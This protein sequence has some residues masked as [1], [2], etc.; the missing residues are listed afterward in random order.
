[1]Y[2]L[3]EKVEELLAQE[4]VLKEILGKGSVE[5]MKAAFAE[6]GVEITNEELYTILKA[7]NEEAS[8]ALS[9]EDLEN[10]NGGVGAIAVSL[11]ALGWAWDTACDYYGGPAA[12]LECTVNYW[13]GAYNRTKKKIKNKFNKKK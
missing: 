8:D 1:M 7:P 11:G 5:E 2:N 13:V 4:D 10:V 3:S 12:A 6:H 9:A